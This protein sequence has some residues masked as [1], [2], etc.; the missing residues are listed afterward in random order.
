LG[1]IE[2]LYGFFSVLTHSVQNVAN[3][4]YVIQNFFISKI[5]K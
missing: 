3:F 2:L 5:S 1:R 4:D